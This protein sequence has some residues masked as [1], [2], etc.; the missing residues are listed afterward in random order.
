AFAPEVR[1]VGKQRRPNQRRRFGGSAQE[2]RILV[3]GKTDQAEL[4]MFVNSPIVNHDS[5]TEG[6]LFRGSEQQHCCDEVWQRL[7]SLARDST[8]R[9]GSNPA[10]PESS[11]ARFHRRQLTSL[12]RPQLR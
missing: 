8:A 3:S 2:R 11:A 1:S 10:T 6:S 5:N 12:L 4:V 9:R 7:P